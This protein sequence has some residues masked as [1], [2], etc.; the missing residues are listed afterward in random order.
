MPKKKK[1]EQ[2]EVDETPVEAEKP[3]PTPKAEE[4]PVPTKAEV[5][6]QPVPTEATVEE[7]PV[8]PSSPEPTEEEAIELSEAE[9]RAT[10]EVQLLK[11]YE[12]SP[13]GRIPL[14]KILKETGATTEQIMQAWDRLYD[15]HQV[16]YQ[17]LYKP[18]T[19]R[20]ALEG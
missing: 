14:W 4:Q 13:A 10:L 12:E 8:E 3:Q 15:L 1:V 6:E 2:P 17:K 20:V 16:P 7:E 18:E 9:Q 19:G 11:I 5:E